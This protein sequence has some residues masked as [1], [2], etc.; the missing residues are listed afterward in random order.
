MESASLIS[1]PYFP[2]LLDHRRL[3]IV[4]INKIIKIVRII[5]IIKVTL[6]PNSRLKVHSTWVWLLLFYARRNA[7]FNIHSCGGPVDV[8]ARCACTFFGLNAS[9]WGS[10]VLGLWKCLNSQHDSADTMV[11][12]CVSANRGRN[13]NQGAAHLELHTGAQASRLHEP[14][15]AKTETDS[16]TRLKPP[17]NTAKELRRYMW[18]ACTSIGRRSRTVSQ[19]GTVFQFASKHRRLS[20][21]RTETSRFSPPDLPGSGPSSRQHSGTFAVPFD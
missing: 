4:K 12:H 1:L 11:V 21:K 8:C 7:Q 20:G 19:I 9:R 17:L 13:M 18:D 10:R 15:R 16:G 5:K 2:L 6:P 3:K 14:D